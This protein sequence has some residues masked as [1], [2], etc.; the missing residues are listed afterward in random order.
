[1]TNRESVAHRTRK[2]FV[3]P[4][5]AIRA[6]AL[7]DRQEALTEQYRGLGEASYRRRLEIESELS[8]I[9]RDLARLGSAP[10]D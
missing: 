8:A 2:P 6:A 10:S 4:S 7:I 3:P 9:R 5:D 1:M